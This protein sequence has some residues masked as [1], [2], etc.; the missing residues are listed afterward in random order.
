M[1]A[2]ACRPERRRRRRGA[3]PLVPLL[4][5]LAACP[6]P[7]RIEERLPP[8]PKLVRGQVDDGPLGRIRRPSRLTADPAQEYDPAP[9][10]DG[11]A[12]V[13]VGHRRGNADLFLRFLPGSGR[14]GEFPI[15]EHFA[16]DTDPAWSPNGRQI[17]FVSKRDDPKGDLYVYNLKT[18]D[19]VP[20][21]VREAL[22][23]RFQELLARPDAELSPAEREQRARVS[24]YFEG[25]DPL[26]R[27]SDTGREVRGPAWSRDGGTIYYSARRPGEPEN[28]WALDVLTRT[29]TAVTTDGGFDPAP[30]P[31]GKFLAYASRAGDPNGGLKL[32]R[33]A[34][35]KSVSLTIGSPIDGLPTWSTD[36]RTL[37]FTR[38]A[39]DT[40]G[41]GRLDLDDRPSLY[42]VTMSFAGTVVGSGGM[43][44][45]IPWPVTPAGGYDLFPAVAGGRLFYS[46]DDGTNADL[47][48]IPERGIFP[49]LASSREELALADELVNEPRMR[50]LLLEQIGARRPGDDAAAQDA[51]LAAGRLRIERRESGAAE[52][53]LE[54]LDSA[55]DSE[56]KDGDARAASVHR[57]RARILAAA[58]AA[59][60]A[61]SGGSIDKSAL[62]RTAD[63]LERDAAGFEPAQRAEAYLEAGL[64][65]ARAGDLLQ[66][67]ES[68]QRAAREEG[69]GW[70]RAEAGLAAASAYGDLG[71]ADRSVS[72][73]LALLSAHPELPVPAE[74]RAA[75]E[76]E[77]KQRLERIDKRLGGSTER[78]AAGI[79]PAGLPDVGVPATYGERAAAGVATAAI[80]G[81]ADAHA[82]IASLRDLATRHRDLPVLPALA[83]NEI[84][85]LYLRVGDVESATLEYR[86]VAESGLDR[87]QEQ[88]ARLSA[89]K[90]L[91]IAGRYADAV[92][93]V[94]APPPA[95]GAGAKASAASAILARRALSA[96][97]RTLLAKADDEFRD[98]DY[99]LAR[100]SYRAVLAVDSREV[101]AHRGLIASAAALG[102]ADRIAQVYEEEAA[103]TPDD[104]LIRYGVGLA[105]SYREPAE[106][107]LAK[108]ENELKAAVALDDAAVFPHQ[109]LGF[110]YEKREELFG[111]EG[112]FERA[113]DQYLIAL[114]LNEVKED[115]RNESD[116]LLNVGNAFFNLKNHRAAYDHYRRR[117]RASV[118]FDVKGRELV[119]LERIAKC[120]FETNRI[121]E[122]RDRY[123]RALAFLDSL[124][125]KDL[126]AESAAEHR[127]RLLDE[128]AFALDRGGRKSEA[129][130]AYLDAAKANSIAGNEQN[131]ARA[132]R[133]A[134]INLFENKGFGELP[135]EARTRGWD[136][137]GADADR[138]P[139]VDALSYLERSLEGVK[140]DG[141]VERTDER[142]KRA[143]FSYDMKIGL[144]ADTSEASEGFSKAGEK[145]LIFTFLGKIHRALGDPARARE[146]LEKKRAML[147]SRVADEQKAA[148]EF[149][150]ALLENQIGV[151]SHA[152]GDADAAWRELAS[153]WKR[154]ESLAN[155]Q[156]TVVNA[157]NLAWIALERNDA[158]RRQEARSFVD[159]SL[160]LLER[161]ALADPERYVPLLK[162]ARGLLRV[163]D[164]ASPR[165]GTPGA[166]AMPGPEPAAGGIDPASIA[167][168][169]R[170]LEDQGRLLA[171][172][173]A[174]LNAALGLLAKTETPFPGMARLH[175]ALSRA[176]AE[177]ASRRGNAKESADRYA[178]TASLARSH[179]MDAV[180]TQ[181]EIAARLLGPTGGAEDAALDETLTR[182]EAVPAPVLAI[183]LDLAGIEPAY[184]RLAAA[185]LAGGDANGAFSTMERLRALQLVAR[186]GG[187][188][189]RGSG[190]DVRAAADTVRDRR[191]ALLAAYR[192]L[193]DE[194]GPGDGAERKRRRD[195]YD[196]AAAAWKGAVDEWGGWDD[197]GWG[198]ATPAAP[199]PSALSMA[200]PPDT[201]F[202]YFIATADALWSLRCADGACTATR[203]GPS[204][205]EDLAGS[206]SAAA[207]AVERAA[208]EVTGMGRATLVLDV[209]L[210]DGEWIPASFR[211]SRIVTLHKSAGSVIAGYEHRAPYRERR[212]VASE[213]GAAQL[214]ADAPRADEI[215]VDAA[216]IVPAGRPLDAHWELTRP[217][218]P[219]PVRRVTAADLLLAGPTV[220]AIVAQVGSPAAGAKA[221]P[222]TLLALAELWLRAGAGTVAF[223]ESPRASRSSEASLLSGHPGMTASE[224]ATF[225]EEAYAELSAQVS[226]AMQEKRWDDA[227][228]RLERARY[229]ID[230]LQ[231]PVSPAEV[232]EAQVMAAYNAGRWA[233][234][235]RYAAEQV[236]LL[237]KAGEKGLPLADALANL[238]AL[239]QRA[240][241][242]EEATATLERA[243][244]AYQAL[245]QKDGVSRALTSLGATFE[246]WLKTDKALEAFR[247][248]IKTQEEI[249]GQSGIGDLERKIGRVHY[250]YLEDYAEAEAHFAAARDA[251][252]AAK[253]AAGEDEARLELGLVAE[254]RGELEASKK[255]YSEVLDRASARKDRAIE[256]KATL[257]LANTAWLSGDYQ[258]A[259]A[260]VRE[261]RRIG[262]ET[263][264]ARLDFLARSTEGLLHW[265]LNDL[266]R[267]VALQEEA[268]LLARGLDSPI[269]EA[270]THNN[271]GILFRSAREF[272][273][274]LASF[275]RALAIDR[276]I[277][278]RWGQAY[279][280]R[281]IGLT[282]LQ[283]GEISRAREP[284]ESAVALSREIGDRV[285]GAK[286]ELAL[287]EFHRLQGGRAGAPAG[288][289]RD[290]K[291]GFARALAQ[292]EASHLP[293]VAWRAHR[294]LALL[295]RDAGEIATAKA[296]LDAAIGVVENLRGSIKVEELK[297]GFIAD[298]LDLYDDA[299]RLAL[300][301]P[302]PGIDAAQ[303]AWSYSE[304]SRARSFID[305][306]ANRKVDLSSPDD[307]RRLAEQRRLK[308]RLFAAEDALAKSAPAERPAR[309]KELATLR[310]S[311]RDLLLE[312]RAANPKLSAFVTVEPPTLADVRK[313]IGSD[314]ALLEY[315]VAATET[316]VW[317]ITDGS[318]R[319]ERLGIG[320]DALAAAVKAYLS[321]LEAIRP[322]DAESRELWELLL[323]PALH[324]EARKKRYLGIVPHGTLHYVPFAALKEGNEHLVDRASLF[325]V[326]SAAV[327]P[328]TG[329]GVARP[330]ERTA[331]RV[332]AIGNPDLG[333]ASFALPF[334]E[335]E[336][337]DLRLDFPQIDV[338]TRDR[339]TERWVQ[340][341]VSDYRVIHF[342]CHGE[343]DAVNP[344]F[345]SL[346]LARE[347]EADGALTAAEI[348]GLPL[349]AELVTLSACRTGLG[350]IEAGDELIGLNRAFLYAGT[351]SIMSTLWRVHDGSTAVLVKHFYRGFARE[352]KAD[353]LRGA[354]RQVREYYPHPAYWAAFA[355]TGEYR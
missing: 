109:T 51:R 88:R 200:V 310:E 226:Q 37:F 278:S 120:A 33:L 240:E 165:R 130:A 271:L 224:L 20:D 190:A 336:V 129:A 221:D 103:S 160:S 12:L 11:T 216:G 330:A 288:S 206:R 90:A 30:S 230:S 352:P 259:F 171:E 255:A 59:L 29:P 167:A 17:A 144:S 71:Q 329:G 32:M 283:S 2:P 115:Y 151:L 210:F 102:E 293:E 39:H 24:R 322:V 176:S 286:A 78:P 331:S 264:S 343:F 156:G 250:Q 60:K 136:A 321:K 48:A 239:Q 73:F 207:A 204:P 40:N 332:L 163:A 198:L 246:R 121:D 194:S 38:Y 305:L 279:D 269:D 235:A 354:M 267:G 166:S 35:R 140:K 98:R 154:S 318:I 187:R 299:I 77:R 118:P 247:R 333:D 148:V 106:T 277:G 27:F 50:L 79:D 241:R 96:Y 342:A 155:V 169:L 294:G 74:R 26:L 46:S 54:R 219:A 337:G 258:S 313:V 83:R 339:A 114:S 217:E 18:G 92:A 317:T 319:V 289:L 303:V 340:K 67:T 225:G 272:D 338:M 123:D 44:A 53:L 265:T 22:L 260:R 180:A 184:R 127:A 355:L 327:L 124:G 97:V 284:L 43:I 298:K 328:L 84:G 162:G 101:R 193:N 75:V 13:Y 228:V 273:R 243:S 320:R 95:G 107:W 244:E 45:P 142:K 47:W 254:R 58:L 199:D 179:G 168:R 186:A 261:A 21:A 201:V 52:R 122:A 197:V 307:A 25:H 174:D 4:L 245:G 157:A 285:N 110:V 139:L 82:A 116:L 314:T 89:A 209:G 133:N 86:A 280:L 300:D 70:A 236:R 263:G 137:T 188:I 202:V 349:K 164:A 131:S 324:P 146:Q 182:L 253:N 274:A 80:L 275:E 175:V 323:A 66:A 296:Q 214:L 292:A 233:D 220:S 291:N 63:A 159:A 108:A 213:A 85:D 334:A 222:E 94:G 316:Y 81:N 128:R 119:F 8:P 203:E 229:L 181:A 205:A 111:E 351:R 252:R 135:G 76:R 335:L 195:A 276:R 158:G 113:A 287:A 42:A 311:Y 69:G 87:R 57:A 172:A 312:I 309:E 231:I 256:G 7:V 31:D 185:K 143:L 5:G 41:D 242:Y 297:N 16:A 234:G 249:G 19:A 112:G 153:S 348:F 141:V 55:T 223:A 104:P 6:R 91:L 15:A 345:S 315:H 302:T 268:L 248:A 105:Y 306:L 64:A 350:K 346:R 23:G 301:H 251:Y 290:A 99:A 257:F 61:E 353:A 125:E 237:E 281:N 215:L 295:A 3:I 117:E 149:K 326:P 192:A 347:Q 10:P 72:T 147:P 145:E 191:T 34:D 173:D 178:A 308:A 304:R 341:N 325:Y 344:L 14:V 170:R 262:A 65:R 126:P 132:L 211:K 208:G 238:G 177:I 152:L 28:V 266:A 62:R 183:E 218:G 100:K 93:A 68:W 161:A 138:K 232:V 49:E 134:A 227:L 9:S 189:P 1:T 212:I 270:S 196:Q 282:H 36:G 56:E 150:R